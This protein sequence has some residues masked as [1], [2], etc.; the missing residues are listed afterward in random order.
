MFAPP[1]QA[2]LDLTGAASEHDAFNGVAALGLPAVKQVLRYHVAPGRRGAKR[3]IA[4]K[5][6]P[7]L[8]AGERLTKR[9]GSA[10]L[11]DA[12]GSKVKIT[13]PN[14][15]WASNG[16]VHVIDGVLL[17][18]APV[19]LVPRNSRIRALRR[20]A[21]DGRLAVPQRAL[22]PRGPWTWCGS[23]RWNLGIGALHA[24]QAA[25]ILALATAVSLPIT[26]SYLTGPPGA[27]DYG[28]PATLLDLRVDLA[29]AVFLLLAAVDHLSVATWARDWYDR[30]VARG[31][32]PAR[33]WEYAVSASLMIVL[34]AMLAGV[35]EV[36]ALIAL[37]G[38]N[39]A[40]ILFGLGMERAN[41]DAAGRLAAV[42]LRLHRGSGPWIAIAVQIAAAEAEGAAVPGFVV[43][44]F[45]TLLLLF[46][47]FAVNMWLPVPPHRALGRPA[48]RGTP[49]P[50]AQPGRQERPRL[51]GIRG[52]LAGGSW[53]G[54]TRLRFGYG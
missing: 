1:D 21:R 50:G 6:I 30:Q 14:A 27:G 22:M 9:R 16:V 42:R 46:N 47:S 51:A 37:F 5:R 19:T 41:S 20:E 34:I 49:L 54:S 12:T 32:N 45:V 28:G 17:P 43:A 24:V 36:T 26:A 52:A 15:A 35:R 33:W 11:T 7:T 29:V 18:F 48:I 53:P 40:M 10:K 23:R 8:L 13:A 4:A 25:I 31:I 39:A 3:I 2:F 38:V 44:I